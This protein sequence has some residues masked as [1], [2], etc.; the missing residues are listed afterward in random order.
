MN[1]SASQSVWLGLGGNI[2]DVRLAMATAL[3]RL[4]GDDGIEVKLVSSIYKTP[5][6]GVEDQ[7]WFQNCCAE[8]ATTHSAEETLKLCQSAEH[9]GRRERTLRWGPRTIDIDILIFANEERA[10]KDLVLPHPRMLERAFVLV[11]LNEIA[12]NLCVK[13]R[14]IAEWVS[15]IDCQGVEKIAADASWWRP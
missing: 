6:W 13:G 3:Q 8:I 9:E 1:E 5:P 4:D 15:E 10:T 7:P 12:A 11:P 14:P 2:G